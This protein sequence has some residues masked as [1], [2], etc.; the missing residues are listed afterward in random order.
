VFG[1]VST[2]EEFIEHGV[3][4]EY[5]KKLY[6]L[7]KVIVSRYIQLEGDLNETEDEQGETNWDALATK[8]SR[9]SGI[10]SAY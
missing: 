10:I 8:H 2:A 6:E 3:P 4:K 5:A 9:K 7:V 1:S